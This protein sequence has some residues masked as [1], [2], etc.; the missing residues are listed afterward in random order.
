M[1]L[2]LGTFSCSDWFIRTDITSFI[3]VGDL[4]EVLTVFYAIYLV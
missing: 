2:N 1:E 4:S 3:A